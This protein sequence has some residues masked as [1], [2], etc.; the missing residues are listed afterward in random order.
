MS[1]LREMQIRRAKYMAIW[2]GFVFPVSFLIAS[3]VA[4]YFL[5]SSEIQGFVTIGFTLTIVFISWSWL[6][7]KHLGK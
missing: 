3:Y 5:N 6:S 2:I 7:K 1:E 4:S